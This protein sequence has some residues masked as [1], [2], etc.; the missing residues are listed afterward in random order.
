[1][2]MFKKDPKAVSPVIAIIL[3]VAITVVLASVLYVWVNQ[4]AGQRGNEEL[5][6]PIIEISLV[7]SGIAG[8]DEMSIKHTS[9]DPIDWSKYKIILTNNTDGSSTVMTQL[10]SLGDQSAGEMVL[11]NSTIADFNGIDYQKGKSYQMEIYNLRENKRVLNHKNLI[12][13]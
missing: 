7:D 5:Q 12:C 11:V 8:A 1:M 9:G 13:E 6:F 2:R 4:I 10:N 3:M